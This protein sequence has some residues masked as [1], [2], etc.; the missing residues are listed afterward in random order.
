MFRGD[1]GLFTFGDGA[2][3]AA[4]IERTTRNARGFQRFGFALRGHPNGALRRF[5]FET[6]LFDRGA[7]GR[8][9]DFEI[10]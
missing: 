9:F 8:R 1:F 2:A 5:S 10:A 4:I 7:R 3:F 6:Q